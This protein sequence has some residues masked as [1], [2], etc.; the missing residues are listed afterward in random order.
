MTELAIDANG[1]PFDVPANITGWRVRRLQPDGRGRPELVYDAMG[2]PVVLPVDAGF[3]DLHHAVG[4]GRYRLDPVD[5]SGR[6]DAAVPTACT[7]YLQPIDPA[8]GTAR[9]PSEPLASD[10]AKPIAG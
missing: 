2:R 1:D 5:A 8:S 3:S 9:V 6:A 7:G 10:G 4:P